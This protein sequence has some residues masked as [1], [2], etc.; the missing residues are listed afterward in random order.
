[1]RASLVAIVII[2]ALASASALAQPQ[3][4]T[5][6]VEVLDSLGRRIPNT[7]LQ[8]DAGSYYSPLPV[9]RRPDSLFDVTVYGEGVY[10][11][12]CGAAG[13]LEFEGH[14]HIGPATP[15]RFAIRMAKVPTDGFGYTYVPT[16]SEPCG[17]HSSDSLILLELPHDPEPGLPVEC[18][19]YRVNSPAS[20]VNFVRGA[21]H[22]Q[23]PQE[24]REWLN[25]NQGS[26]TGDARWT[27]TPE[28]PHFYLTHV[29]VKTRMP[30]CYLVE[31]NYGTWTDWSLLVINDVDL[32][33]E[34]APGV[35]RIIAVDAATGKRAA[36]VPI[37][38]ASAGRTDST[39]TGPDG[40][41]EVTIPSLRPGTSYSNQPPLITAYRNG[42]FA[43]VTAPPAVEWVGQGI[44]AAWTDRSL[45]MPGDTVRIV[46]V[47]RQRDAGGRIRMSSTKRVCADVHTA[48]S[49]DGRNLV[50]VYRDSL[51]PG[52]HGELHCNLV[53]PRNAPPG[54]YEA[55]VVSDSGNQTTLVHVA[56][57]A[58]PGS[59]IELEPSRQ[60]YL[61][62]DTIAIDVI[63]RHGDGS[64]L[65]FA[66]FSYILRSEALEWE[67]DRSFAFGAIPL[68]GDNGATTFDSGNATTDTNGRFTILIPTVNGDARDY[69]LHCYVRS[70][71]GSDGGEAPLCDVF[72]ARCGIGIDMEAGR[73]F[74]RVGDRVALNLRLADL[75]GK[76]TDGHPCSVTIYH[77]DPAHAGD[78]ARA[79]RSGIWSTTVRCDSS[80]MAT[81]LCPVAAEGPL[82]IVAG[83]T[84]AAGNTTSR[85]E[86]LIGLPASGSSGSHGNARVPEFQLYSG[87]PRIVAEKYRYAPGDMVRL[88]VLHPQD[89]ADAHLTEITTQPARRMLAR[90]EHGFTIVT[91][92]LLPENAPRTTIALNAWHRGTMRSDSTQFDVSGQ[93]ALLRLTVATDS[94]SYTAGG[95]CRASI[96]ATDAV[97]N[98]VPGAA[99][100]AWLTRNDPAVAPVTMRSRLEPTRRDAA[101]VPHLRS[102]AQ[103]F[104][105]RTY[106]LGGVPASLVPRVWTL[107]QQRISIDPEPH[108]FAFN[109]P[110]NVGSFHETIVHHDA[111]CPVLPRDRT[112][113]T[114]WYDSLVTDAHG[115]AHALI[116]LP[117][118]D[119]TW[120]L[121]A[122]GFGSEYQLATDVR[123]IR[124]VQP[125]TVRYSGPTHLTLGDTA[126]FAAV[127]GNRSSTQRSA[128]VHLA[129]STGGHLDST[130]I[131]PPSSV[132]T[133]R[134]RL[135]AT[136]ADSIRVGLRA[137]STGITDSESTVVPVAALRGHV[138]E[139]REMIT[140]AA[141]RHAETE[142]R[143][144][145]SC[146]SARTLRLILRPSLAGSM[147]GRLDSMIKG[148]NT[149]NNGTHMVL[150]CALATEALGT[151]PPFALPDT[152][153]TRLP[154]LI[155]S[156]IALL[157][158]TQ[159]PSGEWWAGS[160]TGRESLS[161]TAITLYALLR[162]R[163]AGH[164]VP[165]ETIERAH[166]RLIAI[167]EGNAR[168]AGSI[169]KDSLLR[170]GAEAIAILAAALSGT[171]RNPILADRIRTLVEENQLPNNSAAALALAAYALGEKALA[172]RI[173]TRVAR[174][175]YSM[176]T[177][178]LVSIT[179]GDRL[180]NNE[181][182][183]WWSSGATRDMWGYGGDA[184]TRGMVLEALLTIGVE[185]PIMHRGALN[186]M[187][188]NKFNYWRT[189]YGN[190]LAGLS[191]ARYLRTY[192]L[193]V[194]NVTTVRLNGDIVY[195]RHLDSPADLMRPDTSVQ[196]AA[197]LKVGENTITIDA[198]GGPGVDA[199]VMW[200]YETNDGGG[201]STSSG[202]Q[203]DR[204]IFKLS[205]HNVAGTRVYHAGPPDSIRPGDLLLV[206]VRMLSREPVEGATL[207]LPLPGGCI[208][209]GETSISQV[210]RRTYPDSS[211]NSRILFQGAAPIAFNGLEGSVLLPVG[212]KS[213]PL[214]YEYGL[215]VRAATPG[216][217]RVLPAVVA[218]RNPILYGSSNTATLAIREPASP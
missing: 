99:I 123:I 87:E 141:V 140:N 74:A 172:E 125:L 68:Q 194:A 149:F 80:G 51:H 112:I 115:V 171:D 148:C 119:A 168:Q 138:A 130:M 86:M 129:T 37:V 107:Q 132:R 41:A 47:A 116:R 118:D 206:R 197:P 127:V 92:P 30:G 204:S 178:R 207:S 131:L 156:T 57:N 212:T 199:T 195:E 153:R 104:D 5:V 94:T 105:Y 191:L 85:S 44:V 210:D 177:A 157:V 154:R 142:L 152:L 167:L 16:G 144:R 45:Y 211:D 137:A 146:V 150:M 13:Y 35:C 208:P 166:D 63:A 48:I 75:T 88:L 6:T 218:G 31:M 164:D 147:L 200:E 95:Y 169:P 21:T 73:R 28:A 102:A 189:D 176:G 61:R 126:V 101:R 122:V 62:G 11:V 53:I 109:S 161:W 145:A 34:S 192:A 19:L 59:I 217:F 1:M 67:H 46:S 201:D 50:H 82:E 66:A 180:G 76:G 10:D 182:V 55:Q 12:R 175:G 187:K 29:P 97:G 7:S 15:A 23:R 20:I 184:D 24:F 121:A 81:V 136:T 77:R 4:R 209:A 135:A 139:S 114:I 111:A 117:N 202:I 106:L 69:A 84:D 79:H 3:K 160:Y 98:P 26:W 9:A 124:S 151:L 128:T 213:S 108:M 72:V 190:G 183:V 91:L 90:V 39:T 155:D 52:R 159:R 71:G 27:V 205:P 163:Q 203:V 78:T 110:S 18:S 133:V 54:T 65:S 185:Q 103:T 174:N 83:T 93:P 143:V 100:T 196:F 186:L 179:D 8:V 43:C 158:K 38:V 32:A 89:D 165:P 14:A 162:A 64:P 70:A 96:T 42:S 181:P 56:N 215:V 17:F 198:T 40:I 49:P 120:S 173:A 193:P 214:Q 188:V 2:A 216:T 33:V 113:G 170:P 25:H 22:Y 134:L 60:W 36:N 58:R